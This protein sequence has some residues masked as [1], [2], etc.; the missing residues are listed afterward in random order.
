MAIFSKDSPATP[1]PPRQSSPASGAGSVI[2][3]NLTFEGR[4]GGDQPLLIEGIVKGEI[5]LRSD[6]RIGPGARIEATVHARN[7]LVE[8]SVTGD[9]SADGRVELVASATVV[10]NIRSPKIIVAEGAKFRGTVDMGS[11]KPRA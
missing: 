8:G 2:G 5:A 7:I 1:P 9:L 10:G 4:I 6:L 3:Q 11:E